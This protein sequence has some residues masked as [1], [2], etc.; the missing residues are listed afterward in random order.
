MLAPSSEKRPKI[1]RIDGRQ[2]PLDGALEQ[3][4]RKID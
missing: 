4:Q 2:G 1:D 3:R